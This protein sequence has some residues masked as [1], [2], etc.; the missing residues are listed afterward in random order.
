MQA[1]DESRPSIGELA[2]ST[3]VSLPSASKAVSQLEAHGLVV[4][5]REGARVSVELVDSVALSGALRKVR[6]GRAP[7]R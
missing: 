1:M 2:A 5:H 6:G 4:K 3:G 7:R